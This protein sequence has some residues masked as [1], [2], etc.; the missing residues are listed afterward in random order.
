VIP[1]DLATARAMWRTRTPA[2][3]RGVNE[4]ELLVGAPLVELLS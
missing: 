3:E 1:Y 2:A 4:A